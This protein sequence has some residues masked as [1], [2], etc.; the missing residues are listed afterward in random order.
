MLNKKYFIVG[1][2][3][4]ICGLKI[5]FN[6][7]HLEFINSP[8]QSSN[9]SKDN[10]KLN[11]N[12][13]SIDIKGAVKI[14]GV[15]TF[16]EEVLL[17]DAIKQAGGLSN[18]DTSCIN[19]ARKLKDGEMITIPKNGTCN[20]DDLININNASEQELTLLKGIGETRAKDI[21][22]YRTQ[23][24]DFQTI[25]DIKNVSGIGDG[26]FLKIQKQIIV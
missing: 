21:V 17:N 1:I 25:E 16:K 10:N 12:T 11:S 14:P 20:P 15:Y 2:I 3:I 9:Q 18:A 13:I 5:I 6:Y 8:D 23:N 19:L 7:A 4:I 26:L 22:D 24:G